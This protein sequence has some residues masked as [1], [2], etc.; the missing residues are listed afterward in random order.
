MEFILEKGDL[1]YIAA[2]LAHLDT[3][4]ASPSKNSIIARDYT[5]TRMLVYSLGDEPE[6]EMPGD[7]GLYA[8][9]ISKVAGRATGDTRFTITDRGLVAEFGSTTYRLNLV[10]STSETKVPTVTSGPH[11]EAESVDSESA[12]KPKVP[13]VTSTGTI[14]ARAA[15]MHGALKDVDATGAQGVVIAITKDGPELRGDGDGSIDCWIPI[16]GAE[17]DGTGYSRLSLDLLLPCMPKTADLAL[18]ITLSPKGP[19]IMRF[20]GNMT[21]YQAPRL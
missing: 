2:V 18:E 20:G 6:G 8:P 1:R 19:A 4:I 9:A 3:V 13:T 12:S 21:Y 5:D 16:P 7:V 14:R 17:S 11:R 15:D 10:E